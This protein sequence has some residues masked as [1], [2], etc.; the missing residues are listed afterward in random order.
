MTQAKLPS[1]VSGGT[2]L[3]TPGGA[4]HLRILKSRL[5]VVRKMDQARGDESTGPD[6]SHWEIKDF[7]TFRINILYRMLDRQLLH[8]RASGESEELQDFKET[9]QG[10]AA[11]T[12]RAYGRAAG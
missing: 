6:T 1:S 4:S 9:A 5:D 12:L 3:K 2:D 8:L 10:G 7:L 11:E